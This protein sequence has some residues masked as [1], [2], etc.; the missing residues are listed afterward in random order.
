VKDLGAS[1]IETDAL[2]TM[3]DFF[4]DQ[5]LMG[6]VKALQAQAFVLARLAD[7]VARIV[8]ILEDGGKR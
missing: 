7:G 6:V 1:G 4:T 3:D 8:A 2:A 5:P